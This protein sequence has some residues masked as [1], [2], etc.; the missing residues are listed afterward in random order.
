MLKAK[1]IIRAA[2]MLFTVQKYRFLARKKYLEL[3]ICRVS[4]LLET[5]L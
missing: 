5:V 4:V 1:F 3:Y 2:A